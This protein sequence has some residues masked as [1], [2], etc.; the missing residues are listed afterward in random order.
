M[1]HLLQVYKLVQNKQL[2]IDVFSDLDYELNEMGWSADPETLISDLLF[3][4]FDLE[5]T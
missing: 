2:F 3:D 5:I 4:H 1:L